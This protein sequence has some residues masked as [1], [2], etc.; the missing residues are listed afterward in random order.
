MSVSP[1]QSQSDLDWLWRAV[2]TVAVVAAALLF[3]VRAVRV[4]LVQSDDFILIYTPAR[5]LLLG[6]N[7]YD[8]AA[9][10]RVWDEAGGPVDRR[11]SNREDGALIYPLTTLAM[12]A[13]FAAMPWP[14]AKDVWLIANVTCFVAIVSVIANLAGFKVGERRMWVFLALALAFMPVHTTI[15]LGQTPLFVMALLVIAFGI[16]HRARRT[17][18]GGQRAVAAVGGMVLAAAS[19]VKPQIG[20]PFAALDVLRRRWAPLA[21]A[22]ATA[23]VVTLVATAPITIRGVPWWSNWRTNLANFTEGSVGDPTPANPVRHQLLNLHYPLHNFIDSRAAVSV[24]VVVIAAA[25]A[26]VFFRSWIVQWLRGPGGHLPRQDAQAT[27]EGEGGARGVPGLLLCLSMIAVLTLMIVYHRFYDGVLLLLP[28]G[29]AIGQLSVRRGD[30]LAWCALALLLPYFANLATALKLIEK[31]A[32]LPSWIL[33]QWWW[34]DL[35]LPA[36]AWALLGLAIVLVMA[37]ERERRSYT[38]SA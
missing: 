10:D 3:M 23:V 22:L 24:M 38:A 18:R 19:L 17:W 20:V 31:R 37:G 30:G 32:A 13:P 4:G 27:A 11:P 21:A 15:R 36:Q 34:N 29:W 25:L 26:A 1:Q 2:V 6:E 16:E 12:L 14:L 35:L 7:P 5:A 8:R 28:L 9:I 33:D